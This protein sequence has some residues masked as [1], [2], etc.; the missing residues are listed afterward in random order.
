MF[1]LIMFICYI[2]FNTYKSFANNI[3][4]YMFLL[5][6]KMYGKVMQFVFLNRNTCLYYTHNS[7][8]NCSLF[9]YLPIIIT[10]EWQS[11]LENNGQNL[12]FFS[13]LSNFCVKVLLNKNL[14]R[15]LA[16][17]FHFLNLP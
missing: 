5:S 9:T 1:C 11:Y 15:R 12:E 17:V 13:C 2:Q 7:K 6:H 10:N 16:T 4:Y 8:G 14:V 3:N